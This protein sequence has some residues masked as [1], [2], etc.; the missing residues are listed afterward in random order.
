L[1]VFITCYNS[2]QLNT[3]AGVKMENQNFET[4]EFSVNNRIAT[5]TLNRPESLNSLNDQIARE[6]G[7]ALELCKNDQIKVVV[8]SGKGKGFSSGGD[9]KLMTQFE[10]S[11]DKLTALLDNLHKVVIGMR[12]LEKPIIASIN[13][14]AMG[15]G[16]SLALACDFRIAAKSSSFSCAFVNIGLVPDSGASF[17]LTKLLGSAKATELMF[18]GDTFNTD[19]AMEMGLLNRVAPDEDLKKVVGDFAAKLAKR[20]AQSIA[21]IKHLIN[22]AIISDLSDQLALEAMFQVEA[23]KTPDFKEGITAF[24]EKRKAE[25]K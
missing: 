1:E 6:L 11:P 16:L 17:F 18:L 3:D 4:I 10:S 14:F 19:Q 2:R 22:R 5:I 21:K 8:L 9:I 13:G 25:F 23:I 12:N 15:A 7:Q 24:I 20:P